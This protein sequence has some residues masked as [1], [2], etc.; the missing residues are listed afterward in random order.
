MAA[1]AFTFDSPTNTYIAEASTLDWRPGQYP[2]EITLRTVEGDLLTFRF[3]EMDR[4]RDGNVTG[5]CYTEISPVR[6]R[7]H[8]L[9]V[10][11]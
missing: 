3:R 8:A 7:S 10:N 6:D 11:D 9:I 1:N 2:K 5:F 4:D